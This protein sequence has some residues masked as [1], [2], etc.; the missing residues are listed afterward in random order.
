MRQGDDEYLVRQSKIVYYRHCLCD[1]S[2][3]S[4]NKIKAYL[5]VTDGLSA[6]LPPGFVGDNKVLYLECQ[7]G[8]CSFG[9]SFE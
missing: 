7:T 3:M 6:S 1:S 8:R 5:T 4:M 9:R 2:N